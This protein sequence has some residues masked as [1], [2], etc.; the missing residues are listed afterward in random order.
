MS[1]RLTFRERSENHA[2]R[3][4]T[5]CKFHDGAPVE[6]WQCA[7]CVDG[8]AKMVCPDCK[9]PMPA[10]ACVRRDMGRAFGAQA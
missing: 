7:W 6:P 10:C 9:E 3:F 4:P 1:R 2:R 8:K 5:P